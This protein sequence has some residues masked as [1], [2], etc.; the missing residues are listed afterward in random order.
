MRTHAWTA[1]YAQ[2]RDAL[3]TENL[4]LTT[5]QAGTE[6]AAAA[7]LPPIAAARSVPAYDS[8]KPSRMER[9]LVSHDHRN[10]KPRLDVP[11]AETSDAHACRAKETSLPVSVKRVVQWNGQCTV[12]ASRFSGFSRTVPTGFQLRVPRVHLR[13][14]RALAF[15]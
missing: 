10:G 4:A 6:R 8:P 11:V 9:S 7:S 14:V 3:W 2:V 1:R 15:V 5:P 13:G 12:H